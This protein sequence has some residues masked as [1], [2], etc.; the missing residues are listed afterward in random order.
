MKKLLLSKSIITMNTTDIDAIGIEDGLIKFAGKKDEGLAWV[1]NGEIVDYETKTIMPAFIDAHSHFLGVA[2]AFLEIPLEDISCLDELKDRIEGHIK[3]NNIKKGDW[4][5][6]KGFD[7][8]SIKE[9][10]YP[11]L[12]FLDSFTKDNPV[13]ITH[14]SNHTGM[15]NSIGLRTV[16]IFDDTQNPSGGVIEK[17]NGKCTGYLEENA[18]IE[19]KKSCP[20][21]SL[22]KFKELINLAQ[23]KYAKN[24]ITFVQEGMINKEMIPFYEA[25]K[26]SLYLDINAYIDYNHVDNLDECGHFYRRIN[27]LLLDGYKIFIDGS[28]QAK[29]AYLSKPYEGSDSVGILTMSESDVSEA[30]KYAIKHNRQILAHCNG[31]AAAEIFINA[32]LKNKTYNTDIRPVMIHAQLLR[33][34]QLDNVK[35]ANIIPSFFV[36][37]IYYWGDIHKKNLGRRAEAISCLKST[38]EK[39]ILFTIHNDSPVIEPNLLEAVGIACTRETKKG[40]TLGTDEVIS[41]Y[42]ALKAITIN[43]SYQYHEED[44][45]GDISVGKFADLIVLDD[46]PL[47]CEKEKIKDIKVLETIKNGKT[48]YKLV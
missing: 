28:P 26:D 13:V 7:P 34:D 42:E 48:I 36:S 2:N 3:N 38:I 8:Y 5:M 9:G 30:V 11:T 15:M 29:T 33:Q 32:C 17:K 45:R 46:S 22:E 21:P 39:D 37:H 44:K 14:V 19:A 16:G 25:C 1:E 20:T 12:E 41:P 18:F 27:H 40:E 10:R 47:Y 4:V 24:G 31:D 23:E 6:A 43:A 35:K